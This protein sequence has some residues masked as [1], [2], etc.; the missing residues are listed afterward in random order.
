MVLMIFLTFL[1]GNAL[2]IMLIHEDHGLHMPMYFLLSQLSLMDMMLVSTIVPRMA[3]NY[4]M[5]KRSIS[6]IGCGAQIFLYL[7]LGGRE[8][9]ILVAMD[10]DRY[11]T[12]CHALHYI[13]MNQ[14]LCLHMTSGSGTAGRGG[15]ADADLCHSELPLLPLLGNQTLYL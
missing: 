5:D 15:W 9:F 7:T 11:M 2:M 3:A 14:K 4:L 6:P 13:L 10:Y 8:C 12:I 1:M